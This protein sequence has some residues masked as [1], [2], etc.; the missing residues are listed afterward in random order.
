MKQ[1]LCILV[2][3]S[4]GRELA[5]VISEGKFKNVVGHAF[6]SMHGRPALTWNN[7][8]QSLQSHQDWERIEILGQCCLSKLDS[9]PP[10][11]NHCH[12]HKLGQCF[13]LFGGQKLID[14][15]IQKGIYL[16]TPGWV[17][18]WPHWMKVWGFEQAMAREFFAE[19]AKGLLMLDT[20]V[21]PESSQALQEFA[22]FVDLPW[23]T[24]P[25]GLDHFQLFIN[26]LILEWRTKKTSE[27]TTQA[28]KQTSD[29][30]MAM[31]LL[32]N[33]VHI[34]NEAEAI[35]NVIDIF[36]MLFAASTILYLP[37]H[38]GE[39]GQVQKSF[40][41]SAE[42]IA[43]L[44][45]RL[46]TFKQ[47][48]VWT[49]S[50]KGF[51]LRM[52]YH[53]E[54]LGVLEV[55]NLTFPEYKE[56]YLNL[57]L[58]L[59][60]VCGLSIDNARTYQKIKEAEA[61]VMASNTQLTA[62]NIELQRIQDQLQIAKEKAEVANQAK[63]AFLANMSHELRTPLNAIL[64]FAQVMNRST[65]LP[66]DHRDNLRI[67]SRSGEHLLT[68]INQVLDLSKIE[69]GR[70]TLNEKNFD[71]YRLLDELSDMFQLKAE[72]K[73]LQL[74]FDRDPLVPR[75][76]CTDEVKLRQV[77]INFLNNALK[78]TQEGGIAVR[79]EKDA[80]FALPN[81]HLLFAIEDT[82]P[83]IAPEELGNLFEAF[84][85]TKTGRQAQEGTGLGLPI[86]RRFVQLMGGEVQVTS[87]LEHGTTFHFD[88]Q[89][90]IV[91]REDIEGEPS[92][93][94]VIALAPDQPRYR[95]LI[96]DDSYTNRLLLLKLFN[97]LGF[98]LKE[99]SNGKEALELWEEW[100]PHLIWMDMRM[101]V[102]DGYEAARQIKA[103]TKGQA[104][105]VIALTASTLEEERAVVLSAGC[106][107][108]LRKPFREATLF[109]AL[110]KHIGVRFVYEEAFRE[111]TEEAAPLTLTSATLATLAPECLHLLQQAVEELDTETTNAILDQI[112]PQNAALA[113]ALDELVRGYRFDRIQE[114]LEELI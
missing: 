24:L 89:A 78:F 37:L 91:E 97:P 62:A 5:T 56:R 108:Y 4:Y 23:E 96:V 70:A 49:E 114:L 12:L 27:L 81:A 74:T 9:P 45:Q 92:T 68:L 71:L 55:D 94:R 102:M 33:L 86:S 112:R 50:G 67:I 80:A 95:L 6:P 63:S 79:V 59:V 104:T 76:L 36:T 25:V 107:D 105:A 53:N 47:E 58:T 75:Y 30:A 64:G 111:A 84:G 13:Y 1:K 65:D 82:G 28:Q 10:E 22:Q 77:L 83:G 60:R 7:F 15:Y 69:A 54:T 57:A 100:S 21:Y 85:Q 113:N 88:L 66:P 42:D 103:T 32:N 52:S 41:T 11:L 14:S 40:S 110:T 46:T 16:L 20:G 93:R 87:R 38:N 98:E 90:K 18:R 106:D 26:K 43:D 61:E 101:P 35:Q 29:Y 44:L 99:A 39:P 73:H 31:D 3:E 51:R 109:E 2:C 19:F 48:Y 34:V 17:A 8:Q 72:D